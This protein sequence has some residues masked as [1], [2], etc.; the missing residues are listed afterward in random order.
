[1]DAFFKTV[2]KFKAPATIFFRGIEL[3]LL[4][5]KLTAFISEKTKILDIGCGDGITGVLVFKRKVD[6]GLDNN[7]VYIKAIKKSNIYKQFFLA[8]AKKI[9]LPDSNVNLVFSN[10]VVEHI[11]NIDSVLSEVARVLN[12]RG[13]FIFT[14]PSDNLRSYNIFSYLRLSLLTKIYGAWRNKKFN[15]YHCYSKKQWSLIL[16]KHGFKVT[17]GYYYLDKRTAEYWDF[18][19]ILFRLLNTVNRSFANK[20]YKR[21]FRNSIYKNYQTARFTDNTGAAI[22]IIAHKK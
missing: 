12:K 9:P 4:Q 10:C 11:R 19:L 6:Y 8:D 13:T 18:L 7:P 2:E 5:N 21:Y 15:H 3:K 1:M 22:C 14:T 17:D 20:I 16:A